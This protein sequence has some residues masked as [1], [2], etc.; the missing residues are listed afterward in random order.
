MSEVRLQKF[1]AE[2][3]VASRREAESMILSGRVSVDG[4]QITQL[5]TKI[6]PEI[7]RVE[8]DGEALKQKKTKTYIAFYKPRGVLSTMK[9]E[10]GRGGHSAELN[11]GEPQ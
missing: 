5:G 1:L 10:S 9:D 4:L 8:V 2:A 11:S 6:N 3:G 7:A